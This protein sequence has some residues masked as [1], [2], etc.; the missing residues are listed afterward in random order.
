MS[1]VATSAPTA[2]VTLPPLAADP[3]EPVTGSVGIPVTL[4]G[5]GSIPA[6]AITAYHWDFG[7]GTTGDGET[8]RHTYSATGKYTTTLTVSEGSSTATSS[9]SVTVGPHASGV[10]IAVQD[11]NGQPVAGADVVY[12]APDGSRINATAD[13]N[14]VATLTGMPDGADNVLAWA[15][16]YQVAT[17]TVTVSGGTGSATVN[18][19]P[20]QVASATLT[21]T[22][23]TLSQIKAL[24]IDTSDP[25]NQNVYQFHAAL[26][27]PSG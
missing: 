1:K 18:L 12:M 10:T 26:K 21:S 17:G 23:L 14:G 7:D 27:F 6:S 24:G 8:V 5:S 19:V 4:D 16:G 2:P 11:P 13:G 20:G 25:A 22:Q 9:V 15:Q 3:G